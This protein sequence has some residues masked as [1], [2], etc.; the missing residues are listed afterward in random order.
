M[1]WKVYNSYIIKNNKYFCKQCISK[2]RN[3]N[4]RKT[5]LKNGKSFEQWCIENN[6]QDVLDRWDYELNKWKPDEISY[7]SKIKCW[8]KCSREIHNSELKNIHVFTRGQEG[9]IECN[10]CNSFAQWGID[11]L[12]EDFLEEYWD[13]EKNFNIDPWKIPKGCDNKVW[14]ICRENKIHNSYFPLCKDFSGKNSRCP[15][16]N[17]SKG[18][19]RISVYFDYKSIG[20]TP[21]KEFEGLV[22]LKNGNLSYDFYLPQYNLLVEYQGE[23]HDGTA[24]QQTEKEFKQQQEH[25]KRKRD[26]AN[27]N[28]IK[29]LEIW[30]KDFDKIE[31]ILKRELNINY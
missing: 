27:K 15:I 14:I 2:E 12:G 19:K 31:E 25:D 7:G 24:Y 30:Y 28:N 29:L 13:Y 5:K 17:Q 6:R 21:Q 1:P 8:F 4:G 11:N 22:G 18:E 26:Y 20:Y 9:S 3:E 10:Q 16:C 23:F